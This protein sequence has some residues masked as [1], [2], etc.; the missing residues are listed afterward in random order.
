MKPKELTDVLEKFFKHRSPIL[1]TGSPGIGKTEIVESAT[2]NLDYKLMISHPVVGD[3]TDYKGYPFFNP[4]TETASFVPFKDLNELIT[5]D[6]PIVYFL[7]D[8]G[9]APL[10]VQAA[11]MQLIL[12]RQINGHKVSDDV[13]FVAATNRREDKAGVQR[14]IEPLKSRFVSIIELETDAD[15]W[16]KWAIANKI[17]ERVISFIRWKPDLLNDFEPTND[18]KNTPSPRTNFNVSR[19]LKM[20]LPFEVTDELV[21]GAV[22]DGYRMEF[23]AFLKIW[24][25]LPNV[26]SIFLNPDTADVPDDSPSVMYALTG[27]VAA[28]ASKSNMESICIYSERIPP[29]FSVKMI[30]QCI[31][32]D[33]DV[34]QTKAFIRWSEA[35]H[36]FL[37]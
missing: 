28:Q 11:A 37:V 5:T 7:D 32:H 15:Q 26:K 17:D 30:M 29:E 1:L 4:E 34:Q 31:E 8:L 27:A 10:T 22:G 20:N 23:M 19:I 12:G 18:L 13:I 33:P 35:H 25:E 21:G 24:T 3:P 2:T 9:Q 16:V 6:V 36:E 14:L